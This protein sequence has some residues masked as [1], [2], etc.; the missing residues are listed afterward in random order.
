[1]VALVPCM[2]VSC[3][4]FLNKVI[5]I[6]ATCVHPK[7]HKYVMDQGW[8]VHLATLGGTCGKSSNHVLYHLTYNINHQVV[9][10]LASVIIKSL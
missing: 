3:Q 4:C 7:C 9:S 10:H 8:Y 5:I 2:I 6:L 1:M